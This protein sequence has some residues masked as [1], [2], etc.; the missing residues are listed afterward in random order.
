VPLFKP[1]DRRTD[2]R[3]VSAHTYVNGL[4]QATYART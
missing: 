4:V 3:L 2:W 1:H